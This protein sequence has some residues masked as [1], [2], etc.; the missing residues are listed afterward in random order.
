MKRL[1]FVCMFM[2]V[3]III[4]A[5]SN[6]LMMATTTSTDNTG[7]LE[8]LAKKAEKELNI[9]L[10]WIAVGTG[11][12]LKHG[13]NCD[14][15]VLLVHAEREEK[16]FME[17]GYGLKRVQF[18]YNDFVLLGPLNDPLEISGMNVN[19]AL[20]ILFNNKNVKFISRG[21]ESGTHI[22]EKELWLSC[23][24]KIPTDKKWYIE[25]GKGMMETILM[26]DELNA[27]TLADR[28][29]YITYKHKM[30]NPRL[31]II[32]ENAEI[33]RN[34]YS[35]IIVNPEKCPN[36]NINEANKFLKWLLSKET[37]AYIEKYSIN[38]EKLFNIIYK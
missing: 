15:D 13:E 26:A 22:K 31:K 34:P 32:S 25:N 35:I 17:K 14:V 7:L 8:Y 33:L 18:M 37:L 29:T 38:G 9:Q 19:D 12:A 24:K 23:C 3:A 28:S 30:D 11:M 20:R 10:K 2:F 16:K 36:V 21:D 5:E 4:Y 1:F 27:Y 6:I